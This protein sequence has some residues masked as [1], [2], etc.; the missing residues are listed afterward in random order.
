MKTF[1]QITEQCGFI[2]TEAK[3]KVFL[4]KVSGKV[5]A[6]VIE[7]WSQSAKSNNIVVTKVEQ[8]SDDVIKVAITKGSAASLKRTFRVVNVQNF[9]A[10]TSKHSED[11]QSDITY[12][13]IRKG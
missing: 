4:V 8:Y 7:A 11:D 5:N 10:L 3:E 13:N 2:I 6:D 12:K 9:T 1:N